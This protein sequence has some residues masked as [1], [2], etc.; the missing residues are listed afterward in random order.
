MV[1]YCYFY[2][3]FFFNFDRER[4][5]LVD[6]MKT[7]RVDWQLTA[8]II[9]HELAHQWFGNLMTT[10]WWDTIWLNEGFASYFTPLG[11]DAVLYISGLI[12]MI[13]TMCM[14]ISRWNRIG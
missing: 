3:L 11:L 2:I 7:K 14:Y 10:D 1:A 12:I 6:P 5:L 8:E 4:Y 9:S 13:Y